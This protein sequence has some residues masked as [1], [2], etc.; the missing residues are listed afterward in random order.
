MNR[1][2]FIFIGGIL[3]AFLTI[4]GYL[5]FQTFVVAQADPALTPI[6]LEAKR[7]T[8]TAGEISF[9][10]AKPAVTSIECSTS[11]DGPF[12]LCGAEAMSTTDHTIKTSIILDPDTTYFFRIVI[13]NTTYDKDGVP[14]TLG[15]MAVEEAAPPDAFPAE[16]LGLCTDDAGYDGTYD[17]NGDGCIRLNDQ[18]MYLQQ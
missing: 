4:G 11:S 1:G 17:L 14:Y 15:R 7:L 2:M 16:I 5:L 6:N 10:T 13:N 9:T 8:P 3:L 12:S 18:N